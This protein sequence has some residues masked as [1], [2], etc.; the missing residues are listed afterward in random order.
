MLS[1]SF[2][3]EEIKLKSIKEKESLTSNVAYLTYL[4]AIGYA[5]VK[6]AYTYE[7]IFHDKF[8]L[9][10]D[11]EDVVY[12]RGSNNE[13]VAAI[14][15]NYESFETSRTWDCDVNELQKINN[16]ISDFNSLWENEQ[17]GVFVYEI[18]DEFIDCLM[19]YTYNFSLK[20][21]KI[22][23]RGDGT[24]KSVDL[25]E[26]MPFP[27][28]PTD[29]QAQYSTLCCLCKGTTLVVENLF[30]TRY[31]YA[32]ELKRMGADITVRGRTAVIRG[33]EK[34]HGARITASDLRGGAA[35]VIA[36]LAAE[37]Q[38]EVLDLS[39]VDRGYADF[40]YKLK[41]LGAKIRRIKI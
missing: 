40:E 6:I 8:G 13:T 39:H 1:F 33:V 23:L 34:L 9:I 10:Y 15:S 36:A 41:K 25:V 31:K 17:E 37:G 18:T 21:D 26:T 7:G 19:N 2:N 30:E 3:S 20:N 14:K 27:G 12:F 28:F 11:E 4:I 24:L 16:A 5:D 29:L 22:I 32:G 35:L 38:S